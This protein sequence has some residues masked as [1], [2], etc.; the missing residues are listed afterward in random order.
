[1]AAQFTIDW[2]NVTRKLPLEVRLD[3]TTPFPPL[4]VPVG[5]T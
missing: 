3:A 2:L 5:L 1:M 4:S